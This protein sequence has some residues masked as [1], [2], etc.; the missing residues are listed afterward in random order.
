MFKKIDQMENIGLQQ[1]ANDKP[2]SRSGNRKE[3]QIRKLQL[4]R[5]TGTFPDKG[6][7]LATGRSIAGATATGSF[8]P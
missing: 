4:R 6:G 5:K 2:D 3:D 7:P 8:H 1:T